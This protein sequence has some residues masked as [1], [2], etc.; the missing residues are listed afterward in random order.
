MIESF[1][2][3]GRALTEI[4]AQLDSNRQNVKGAASSMPW[5]PSKQSFPSRFAERRRKSPVRVR[6]VQRVEV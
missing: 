3:A 2:N 1:I 4:K 5:I 6:K